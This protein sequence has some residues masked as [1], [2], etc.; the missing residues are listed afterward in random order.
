MA[1]EEI[2][3]ILPAVG[4]DIGGMWA[5]KVSLFPVEGSDR[6]GITAVDREGASD[7]VGICYCGQDELFR[8]NSCW[9]N[10]CLK[11]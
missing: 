9:Y 3:T 10:R 7:W 6:L 2:S 5:G 4:S 8:R 1:R 11:K